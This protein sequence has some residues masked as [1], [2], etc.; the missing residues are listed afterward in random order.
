[1]AD[2]YHRIT[3]AIS[4]SLDFF[5]SISGNQMIFTRRVDFYTSHE[6]LQ[7]PYEQ[8]QTRF[9]DHRGRWYNLSTHMP[10]IGMRT[11]ELDGAH[12]E[13]FRG[14]ANPI[15]IKLGPGMTDDWLLGLIEKLNPDNEA[16]KDATILS[17]P[18]HL[19]ELVQEVDRMM[20]A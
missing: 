18:F 11:A 17:K 8:A 13:Y 16:P 12:V 3:S 20:A 10:W 5:E 9:L 14:I 7:L 6:G 15:G 2:E 4:G 19:R 1:M